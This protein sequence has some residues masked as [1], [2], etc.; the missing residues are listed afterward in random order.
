[1]EK[2]FNLQEYFMTLLDKWWLI[3][4]LTV[5]FGVSS[6]LYS[7]NMLTERFTSYGSVYVNNKATQIVEQYTENNTAN[8]YDLTTAEKLVETYTTILS[9]NTF[10]DLLR[11]NTGIKIPSKALK[12]LVRYESIEET[13]I[14]NIYAEGFSPE[15]AQF[16]CNAVQE[17]ANEVIMDI[18]EVG[19]VKTVDKA[20][21]PEGH[22]Y[23]NT[24]NNTLL[25]AMFG[26]V[27]ACGIIFLI[28][29][30]DIKI[31]DPDVVE[32]KYG[33]TV[34][35]TIPEIGVF[36]DNKQKQGGM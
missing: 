27:L 20:T 10:F 24:T 32:K 36:S 12:S 1:M 18:V 33:I 28:C 34:L 14:I 6:F 29:Y 11:E 26:F 25:G 9:S 21:L 4:I 22:S 31:K 3:G 5:V 13:G 8:L 2:E 15:D 23:P 17:N 30:F 7:N 35:G 16:L 19:S